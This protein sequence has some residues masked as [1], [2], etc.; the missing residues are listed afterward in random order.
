VRIRES[1]GTKSTV[2][3]KVDKGQVVRFVKKENKWTLIEV[4]G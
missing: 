1:A 2:M 3:A 4:L